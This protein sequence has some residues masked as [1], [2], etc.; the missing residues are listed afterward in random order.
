MINAARYDYDKTRL[1]LGRIGSGIGKRK[2]SV[3]ELG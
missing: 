2:I 3:V 1:V